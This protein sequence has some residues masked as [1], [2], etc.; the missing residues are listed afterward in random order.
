ML[1]LLLGLIRRSSVHQYEPSSTDAYPTDEHPER[2][3]TASPSICLPPTIQSAGQSAQT[4]VPSEIAQHPS[5][6]GH[7]KAAAHP[8][9]LHQSAAATKHPPPPSSAATTTI[10]LWPPTGATV[11]AEHTISRRTNRSPTATLPAPHSNQL[12]SELCPTQTPSTTTA[13]TI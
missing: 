3:P 8:N 13:A 4:A 7:L 11:P 2:R 10:P 12:H 9:H 6:S 1:Y 5:R